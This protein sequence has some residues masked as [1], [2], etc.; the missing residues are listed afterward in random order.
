[1]AQFPF[2]PL[3]PAFSLASPHRSFILEKVEISVE[4]GNK[5]REKFALLRRKLGISCVM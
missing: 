5:L 2:L 1:M 4:A 3:A